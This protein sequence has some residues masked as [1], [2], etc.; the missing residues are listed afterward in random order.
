MADTA[1]EPGV[2]GDNGDCI[3]RPAI[4]TSDGDGSTINRVVKMTV[5]CGRVHNDESWK[6]EWATG[7]IYNNPHSITLHHSGYLILAD[8]DN[9][10][11]RLLN[12]TTGED[13]GAWN[14]DLGFG[15]DSGKPF[16]VRTITQTL[17]GPTDLL[18][19]AIMNNPQD[20]ND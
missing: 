13:L 3:K 11:L 8:R 6:F 18:A 5:P 19:V 9:E 1:I 10:E 17:D 14:V 15:D 20:G 7:S 12:S 2:I 4:Y 16:G